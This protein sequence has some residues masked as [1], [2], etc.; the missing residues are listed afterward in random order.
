MTKLPSAHLHLNTFTVLQ[1][2]SN[3]DVAVETIEAPVVTY[4][5][6]GKNLYYS[7]NM[8]SSSGNHEA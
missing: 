8:K 2:R 3:W 7:G 1:Y 5:S 6:S 4:A